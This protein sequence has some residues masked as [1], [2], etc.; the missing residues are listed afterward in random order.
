M[1][2]HI[3]RVVWPGVVGIGAGIAKNGASL[4]SLAEHADSVEVGS[5][6]RL[7]RE[8]N[9]GQ[10]LW[11]YQEERALRHNAGMPNM[12][13]EHAVAEL[14]D[15]QYKLK[16]PWGLN[17]A[18][19]P[20]IPDTEAAV[21]DIGETTSILLAGLKPDWLTLNVS[22]PDSEDSVDM[23]SAPARV[24]RLMQTIQPMLEQAGKIP[25]W[26]KVPPTLAKDQVSLLSAILIQEKAEAVIV[27]NAMRDPAGQPGG[28][29]GEAVRAHA[30]AG[31]WQ[32][33]QIVGDQLPI[34]ATGGVLEAAHVKDK[35]AVGASAVQVVSALLFRGR[36]AASVIRHEYELLL[37]RDAEIAVDKTT[38]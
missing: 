6:T 18:V 15:A 28:W 27:S 38:R 23:L 14:K 12:G 7:L 2:I 22:S 5:I 30:R 4:I 16:V 13:A 29:C 31:V 25:L 19:T 11:K 3:G 26:V 1:P 21:K 20:G 36:D 9:P 34:V 35:L 24:A 17:V 8:G 37:A 10:I 33:K 32:W